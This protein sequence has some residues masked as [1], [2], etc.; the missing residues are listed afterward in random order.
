[1]TVHDLR[2]QSG[3]PDGVAYSSSSGASA[4]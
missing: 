1:M 4:S 3:T 2:E